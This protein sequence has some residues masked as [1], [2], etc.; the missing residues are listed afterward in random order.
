[1]KKCTLVVL[2][3][4]M[5]IFTSFAQDATSTIT[6]YFSQQQENHG[7]TIQD[8]QFEITSQSTSRVSG[9]THVYFRQVVNGIPV[10]GSESSAHLKADG[11]LLK[12]NNGFVAQTNAKSG[13]M[14]SPGM[15]PGAAI[16]AAA[17]QLGYSTSKSFTVVEDLSNGGNAKMLMS[18]GGVS[19]LDIP[20]ELVYQKTETGEL[21]L[22]WDL[23]I[24]AVEGTDWWSVRVNASSGQIVDQT[25]WTITC[26]LTHDHA[27]HDR[28][29]NFNANLQ[30]A[31]EAAGGCTECYEVF[32]LPL[33]SPFFGSR[34][35]EVNPAEPVASPF[36]WHDTDGV[37]GAEFTTTRGNNTN[38]YEDG[39]NAGFQP[40][41]G[42]D[43]FFGGVGFEWDIN[44][45]PAN[46]YESAAVTNLFYWTNIIHDIMYQ[47]GLDEASGNFQENNYGRGGIGGDS[48]DSEA[49]D[50]SGTC[51]ANF[52][53]P[54]DGGN[55]RMQ[56]YTC[57][58]RDGDYDNLVII[59]E[60]GHG[61]SNRL[62]GGPAAAG[63]LGNQEQMG[64]GWSDWYGLI[65]TMQPGDAGSDA[66]GV[67][68]YLFNEG[69]TGGGI[70][71]F[72]YSTDTNINPQTYDFIQS[73]AVPHGVGSVWAMMLWEMTW[74]LIDVHGWDADIYN[75]TGDA[76]LD[77]GNVMAMALVTE[78]LKLQ[79]CSP[80][81]VDGRDAILAADQAIY[82]G[83]N[84]CTIWEAFA[85][86]GLGINAV[87]GSSNSVSDGTENFEFPAGSAAIVAPADVCASEAAFVVEGAGTPAGGVYSGPG[88]T[89][90]G[91]GTTFTFDPAAAGVGVHTISYEI[92]DGECTTASTASDDIEV[93]SV[94]DSPTSVGVS[95]FCVG[96]EV[97]VSATP[98]DPT[99]NIRWFDAPTGGTFLFEGTDYTFT[100]TGSVDLWVEETPNDFLSKLVISEVTLETPDRFEIMNVGV[101]TDYTGYRVALSE[102]PFTNINVVN[103]IVRTLGVMD[104]NEAIS[105]SDQPGSSD[106]WGNNIWWD[107]DSGESGWIIILDPDGNVVDSAFWNVTAATLAT[108]DVTIAGFNITAAD[109]DWTGAGA[110]LSAV[111]NDSF[112]RSG[113]TDSATDWP[114][115]CLDA[116]YGEP[117]EAIGIG[118]AGCLAARTLTEVIAEDIAPE[119]TCPE[120]QVFVIEDG[121]PYELP[122]YS[123]SAT[124]SDNCPEDPVITQDPA[125]GT[126]VGPGDYTI[127]LT[128]TDAAGNSSEC[129]FNLTVEGVLSVNE[130]GIDNV[131]TLYPNPSQGQL[132]LRNRSTAV[133]DAVNL[134]DVNGRLIKQFNVQGAGVEVQFNMSDV[135]SGMYFVQI[136]TDQ[137]QSV[138]RIVKQ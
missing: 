41:G 51:N 22:A 80:G 7:L 137:G 97:T 46:Q 73:S 57:G 85:K 77:A 84:Y 32:A 31:P 89:D 62:T 35:F 9:L 121:E 50:G 107:N 69:P 26:N 81:F 3:G 42:S 133:V 124:F 45:S 25:N 79:P 110:T 23:S 24:Q 59:H 123:L 33:E 11:T 49:Q 19:N 128:A 72:P 122:D 28:N 12:I 116:S 91:D 118:F 129:T 136:I 103:P 40:D 15:T 66:R 76:S 88:V 34:T 83:A 114:N 5:G 21:I 65:M 71:P 113:D 95:D 75:F 53:T 14:T 112:Q 70:R 74:G 109:L 106:Y 117:N 90:N 127:T 135:A 87:Q 38:T 43:L 93:L 47:Y 99:N 36:G 13:G 52:G 98:A 29:L 39:D 56:M 55:P 64:E 108:L 134:Y 104:E 48:V 100:P 30:P 54:P 105:W 44:Y 60:Y 132:T 125:I 78:G 131:L 94:P 63:C 8:A 1:M 130:V 61:I 92:A 20:V 111:C 18:N 2:L 126:E 4:V 119:I 16:S 6:N 10:Y 58:S 138:K 96:D 82:G 101:Q 68:T 120:D 102:Q 115:T 37:A 27:D 17:S 86:R 67:G